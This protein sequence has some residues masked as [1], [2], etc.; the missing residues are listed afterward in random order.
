MRRSEKI[1]DGYTI[2]ADELEEAFSSTEMMRSLKKQLADCAL[3]CAKANDYKNYRPD[4]PDAVAE[5]LGS[6]VSDPVIADIGSGT[7][8]LSQFLLPLAK[9]LYAVCLTATPRTV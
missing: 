5:L 6:L 1:A 4:Y 9:T 2:D 8:K 7:G 3:F